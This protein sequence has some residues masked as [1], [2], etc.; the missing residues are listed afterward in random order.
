MKSVLNIFCTTLGPYSLILSYLNTWNRRAMTVWLQGSNLPHFSD[1]SNLM[2]LSNTN[3]LSPIIYWRFDI[4]YQLTLVIM[5]QWPLS[6]DFWWFQQPL[7]G[8]TNFHHNS[9]C[10]CRIFGIWYE[11]RFP[12]CQN[13]P[14]NFGPYSLFTKWRVLWKNHTSQYI[15]FFHPSLNGVIF[16]MFCLLMEGEWQ[17][18]V[19]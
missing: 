5:E 9:T 3:I 2:R 6:I 17:I 8:I 7:D 12:V 19:F 13:D 14:I 10:K 16:P 18:S 15:S 11:A 4:R 1:F